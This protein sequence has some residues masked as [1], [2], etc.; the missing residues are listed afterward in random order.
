ML[1]DCYPV[2]K[3][4]TLGTSL[5]LCLGL[6]GTELIFFIV[7]HRVLCFTFVMKTVLITH[8]CCSCH[9][10]VLALSQGLSGFSYCLPARF[11]YFR[12]SS[13]PFSCRDVTKQLCGAQLLARVK[14]HLSLVAVGSLGTSLGSCR[15]MGSSCAMFSVMAISVRMRGLWATLAHFLIAFSL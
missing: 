6:V 10:A 4:R 5:A 12:L 2:S 11:S 3:S 9:W 14:P 7:A 15:L 8:W 13:P 1:L